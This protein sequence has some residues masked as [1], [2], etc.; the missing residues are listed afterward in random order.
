MS[1]LDL[2]GRTVLITGGAGAIGVEITRL[3]AEHGATV[4]I[5]DIL[6][7]N[8]MTERFDNQIPEG[9]VYLRADITRL[10]SVRELYTRV[11]SEV[12]LP[13]T[14][15][16]HAGMTHAAPLTDY[17]IE[18]FEKL[19]GLNVQ[20][21]FMVAQE[22]V[23]YWQKSDSPGHL[24]FTSSWVHAVPWPEIGPYNA[25]KA[26]LTMLMRSFARELAPTIRANAVA[27]GIVAVG[28]AK[29]QWDNDSGY[30]ARAQ[31]AIPLS[32]MQTPESV[33]HAMLFLCS[34]LA[35]YM[36]GSTLTVDG[37]ASLYPVD[38]LPEPSEDT[39]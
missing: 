26:A 12:G 1:L 14:V 19:F 38:D 5:N 18:V 32:K 36:T 4:I 25:S 22:A 37:G 30:R 17:P 35:D 13:D 21:A 8:E 34:R 6:G 16:C 15:L 9:C 20:A 24:I 33:A 27:P 28:M 23:R 3:L 31:R 2:T 10:E 11:A 29:T 7:E 39:R